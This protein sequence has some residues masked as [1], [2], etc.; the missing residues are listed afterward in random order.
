MS[1]LRGPG[2]SSP[3]PDSPGNLLLLTPEQMTKWRGLPLVWVGTPE[4]AWNGRFSTTSTV[5]SMLDT[6]TVSTRIG[7]AGRTHELNASPGAMT[8]FNAHSEIR[9][10]QLDARNARRVLLHFDSTDIAQHNLFD[11]DLVT[12]P[13]RQ[14]QE[15]Y[16]PD[17]RA[18]LDQMLREIRNG[19]P[20]GHLFAESLSVGVLLHL[21]RTRGVR[22]PPAVGERGKLS[23]WQWSHLLELIE[24]DLTSDLTLSLLANEAGLSKAHFVRLFRNTA[25]DSPHRYVMKLRAARARKMLET[26]QRPLA[27]IASEVGF[28]SQSHLTRVYRQIFGVTP[29]ESRKQSGRVAGED[30]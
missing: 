26:S 5:L 21:C 1:N 20:N 8:L 2:T 25:G 13:L 30:S 7:I 12:T 14:S 16:D 15:F 9:V 17:L 29:G 4:G 27:E 28:A 19:C 6:G 23:R 18:V 10:N 3:R 22:A 24:S 11:D